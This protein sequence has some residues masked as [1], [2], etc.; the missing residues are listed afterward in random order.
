MKTP[1]I[2]RYAF[3]AMLPAVLLLASCG[4]DDDPVI[5]PVDQGKV[6]F[7]HAAAASNTALTAFLNDQ[8]VSQL[9]YGQ[10]SGYVAVNAGTPALR[11]NNGTQVAVP[12]QP[13]TVAKDQSYSV[14][15]Y[16]PTSSIGS[17]ALL[18]VTDSPVALGTGEA[19]VRLVYLNTGGTTPVQL[20]VPPVAGTVG[21]PLTTDVAFGAASG[22][23]KFNAGV[24]NLTITS[25]GTPRPVVVSVGD[26][27]GTGTGVY[28]YQEGKIYTIVVRGITGSGVPTAQQPQAVIIQNN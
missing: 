28:K 27:T 26:G 1:F 19:Q 15:E 5:T 18:T 12:A 13:L 11:I 14:F 22:F 2:L 17:L 20:T 7:S 4:K 6:L 8:Q 24:L 16:S 25:A 3:Q 23:V 21:T 9:N 10:S